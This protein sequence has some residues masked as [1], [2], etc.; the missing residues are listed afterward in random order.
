MPY[1]LTCRF[2][3]I[4]PFVRL[5]HRKDRPFMYLHPI[6]ERRIAQGARKV[7]RDTSA[8]QISYSSAAWVSAM[9]A[10]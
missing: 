5:M 7:H 2:V 10:L 4:M 9:I 1:L 6:F 8:A 3:S